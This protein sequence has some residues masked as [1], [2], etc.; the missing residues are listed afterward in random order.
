MPEA[1]AIA[2]ERLELDV[3]VK[4]HQNG[5][6]GDRYEAV[7]NEPKVGVVF[8]GLLD[9]LCHDVPL[10]V[11]KDSQKRLLVLYKGII[12][13]KN[14]FYER[15]PSFGLMA[16]KR[17]FYKSEKKRLLFGVFRTGSESAL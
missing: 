15:K 2:K 14:N 6:K 16:I 4:R 11:V 12:Q 3:T 10:L 13:S 17:F 7:Y 1:V 8:E 5:D 9:S